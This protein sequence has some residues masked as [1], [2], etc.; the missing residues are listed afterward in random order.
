MIKYI[1]NIEEIREQVKKAKLP[2][3]FVL[4]DCEKI[5]DVG[6]FIENHLNFIDVPKLKRPH[7]PYYNRLKKVLDTL[8]I[9]IEIKERNI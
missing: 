3:E 4:S 1:S 7:R 9:K 5:T 6:L 8:D 2:K